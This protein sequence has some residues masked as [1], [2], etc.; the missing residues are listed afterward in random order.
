MDV[1]SINS[2]IS[3]LNS[4]SS[5]GLE[6]I[7]SS[8][9]VNKIDKDGTNLYISDYNK[10]RDE[11]SLNVQSLNEGIAISKIAQDSISKQQTYL[12]NIQTKLENNDSYENKNDLKQS[13]NEDL[14]SFNQIAYS[15]KFKSENLLATDYYDE[16]TTIDINTKNSNFSIEKPNTPSYA[17]DIFELSNNSDLNNQEALQGLSSKVQNSSD[18]LQN[19]YND[20][21][22]FGNNLKNSAK[23]TIEEQVNL[24]NENKMNK[25][26]NFGQD[27]SDFTKTNVSSN[28]GY[29]AASQA[30]IVQEQSVRL[31]S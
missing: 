1:N 26:R 18:Q 11:L 5:L 25:D 12:T 21:S 24:Y 13:I 30:N 14:K 6:R 4:S 31:L 29:L 8:K 20:F 16:K 15:T 19:S 3:T 27:S 23:D 22:E 7:S 28:M 2:N 9:S 17:N 10:K